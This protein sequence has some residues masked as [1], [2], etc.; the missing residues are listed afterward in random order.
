MST[1]ADTVAA[2]LAEMRKLKEEQ[3]RQLEKEEEAER[4]EE[5]HLQREFERMKAEEEQKEQEA[6]E[7]WKCM[8]LEEAER[9]WE[10]AE[11]ARKH[12]EAKEAKRQEE[13][14]ARRREKGKSVESEVGTGKKRSREESEEMGPA[15]S[16]MYDKGVVWRTREGKICDECTKG[17]RKCFWPEGMRGRGLPLG[18]WSREEEEGGG[19]EG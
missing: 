13:A 17:A 2:K 10:E 16:S 14:E 4:L 8:E 11:E 12:E 1:N 7:T 15:D 19:C 3:R 18:G 9:K 6:E 5:E